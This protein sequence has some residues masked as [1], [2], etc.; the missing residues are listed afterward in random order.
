MQKSV[1][2]EY[3]KL[4]TFD[5]IERQFLMQNRHDTTLTESV[6]LCPTYQTSWVMG[7][8]HDKSGIPPDPD[9]FAVYICRC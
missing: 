2:H 1:L 8:L 6:M 5:L 3:Q 4:S 7:H 9:I